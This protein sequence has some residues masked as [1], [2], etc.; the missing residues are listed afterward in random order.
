MLFFPRAR[1][2]S[3]IIGALLS[4]VAIVQ[5]QVNGNATISAQVLGSQLT[6]G[7]SS[8]YGGG[9]SSITWR[10]KEFVNNWDHGRQVSTNAAFFNRNE[11][12]NPYETGTKED[13]QKL[14]SSSRLLSLTPSGSTLDSRTQMSW[15]LSA[16]DP[17][18]GYGDVC[19]DQAEFLKYPAYPVCPA[20]TRALSDYTLHKTVSIG[21]GGIENVIEYLSDLYIPEPVQ[22]GVVQMTAVLT[23]EFSSV[24]TYD[25]VSKSYRQIRAV[26]GEDDS[27]KVLATADGTHAMGYYSPELLQPYGIGADGRYRWG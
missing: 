14:T 9:I 5:G 19:G 3:G 26:G 22:K 20:S 12:Y 1:T 25:L 7:T 23:L 15:Y 16:C 17:R 18:E 10:G 21:F 2:I 24:W 4:G 6:I 27:V 11:C 13:G 8:Q